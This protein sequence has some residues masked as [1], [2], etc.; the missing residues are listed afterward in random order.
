MICLQIN[1]NFHS[2]INHF[3]GKFWLIA[4]PIH[5]TL[6]LSNIILEQTYTNSELNSQNVML[7]K[8]QVYNNK[9]WHM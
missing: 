4:T 9:I 7:N 3:Y 1:A 6:T 5:K 8:E 2:F